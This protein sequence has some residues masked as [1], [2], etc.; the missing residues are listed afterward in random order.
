MAKKVHLLRIKAGKELILRKVPGLGGE[1]WGKVL[2][3]VLVTAILGALGMLFYVVAVPKL[4]EEFTE[5]YIL[6]LEG[7]AAD[8]P[9]RLA[10]GDE[11]KV[12]VGIVNH[13]GEEVSYRLEVRIDGE[14]KRNIE[15]IALD[16]GQKWEEIVAFTVDKTGDEQKVEF[17]LYKPGQTE[18]YDSAHLR[19]DVE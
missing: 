6:G 19:I 12:I 14:K 17:L 3:I 9:Q 2:S 8:Y 11:G 7:K 16:D 18:V 4:M 1:A 13:E 5:F 15:P 10:V